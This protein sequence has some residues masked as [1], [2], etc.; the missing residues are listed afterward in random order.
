MLPCSWNV[1]LIRWILSV[2]SKSVKNTDLENSGCIQSA[3][4]VFFQQKVAIN[5]MKEECGVKIIMYPE[6]AGWLDSVLSRNISEDVTAFGFNLYE[7][8]G[9]Q[10]S[11]ELVGTSRF[12]A[13]DEDW[14]CDE[15]TDFGTR[16]DPFTWE[17]KAEWEEILAEIIL[18]LRDYLK[19]GRYA[20]VL[21]DRMGVGVGFV[22]GNVE[23]VYRK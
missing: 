21:K 19:S 11:M 12:D 7:D 2:K 18:Y 22:D 20:H 8:E 9:D 1:A 14:C 3:S 15:I 4:A 23:I 17:Q 13:E 16:E 6:I 5:N 10:W